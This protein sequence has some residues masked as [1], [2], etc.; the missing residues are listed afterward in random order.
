[1]RPQEGEALAGAIALEQKIRQDTEALRRS[2]PVLPA[3]RLT[4]VAAQITGTGP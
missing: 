2:H 1:M 4:D 3:G